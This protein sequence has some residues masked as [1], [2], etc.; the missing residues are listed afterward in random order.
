MRLLLSVRLKKKKEMNGVSDDDDDGDDWKN[1]DG[2]VGSFSFSTSKATSKK[3]DHRSTGWSFRSEFHSKAPA[4]PLLNLTE[5][6]AYV[7]L[8]SSSS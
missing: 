6:I 4:L 3:G 8:G 1:D 2:E 7:T 5:E